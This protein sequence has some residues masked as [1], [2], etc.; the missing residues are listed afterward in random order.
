MHR[1]YW[2]IAFKLFLSRYY[3]IFYNDIE[4]EFFGVNYLF[5][6]Y[7]LFC[8]EKNIYERILQPKFTISYIIHMPKNEITP[9]KQNNSE[10]NCFSSILYQYYIIII[11]ILNQWTINICNESFYLV[12]S[13]PFYSKSNV[14]LRILF[15]YYKNLL[16]H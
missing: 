6:D 13:T 8:C 9:R 3:N 10:F 5:V 7:F 16:N 14:V 1:L 15:F 2:R 12:Y 11:I 4:K